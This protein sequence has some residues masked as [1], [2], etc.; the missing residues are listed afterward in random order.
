MGVELE[1]GTMACPDRVNFKRINIALDYGQTGVMLG[2][3]GA[4]KYLEND[5]FIEAAKRVA[6]YIAKRAVPEGGGL[7]FAQFGPLPE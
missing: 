3:A 4:G 7:K 1:D 5:E 2:L 6:N